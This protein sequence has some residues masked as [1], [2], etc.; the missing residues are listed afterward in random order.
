[1][2]MLGTSLVGGV[3]TSTSP[4]FGVAGVLDRFGQVE[5]KVLVGTDGYVYAGKH[6]PRLD[7][8]QRWRPA[9][10][11]SSPSRRRRTRPDA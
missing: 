9:F 2:A 10:P 5:P 1:M 7:R 8:L 6:Q 4:D 3:F 11:P